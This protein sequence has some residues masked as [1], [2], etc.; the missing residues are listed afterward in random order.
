MTTGPQRA[1]EVD[2][3]TAVLVRN[4][5]S[6]QQNLVTEKQL[7]FPAADGSE[8]ILEIR[9]LQKLASYEACIVRGKD[10]ADT[11]YFGKHSDQRSFFLPPYS[12]IV[13]HCWSRGRCVCVCVRARAS[14]ATVGTHAQH[15]APQSSG[16]P[17]SQAQE[18]RSPPRVYVL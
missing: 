1:V 5:R 18:D 16:T 11:F 2:D 10:G 14:P 12:H 15:T 17:G 6:G 4:I 8:E 7:Y 3:S 13:E 9:Q